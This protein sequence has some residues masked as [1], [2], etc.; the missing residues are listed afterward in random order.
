MSPR[1]ALAA[2]AL[3]VFAAPAFAQDAPAAPMSA[4]AEAS[5][6]E[7]EAAFEARG[8]A[9]ETAMEAMHDEMQAAVI[10]AGGD[11]AKAEADLDAIVARYQPQTEVF[12]DELAAFLTTQLPTMPAEAQ[13]QMSEM[14]PVIRSQIL[15]APATIKAAV[16]Q[17]AAEE[18]ASDDVQ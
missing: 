14:G 2:A 3:L 8:D 16:L 11:Q 15:G 4:E 7:A 6:E 13:A 1:I 10:A 17:E 12:A 9:F 5:I 18:A